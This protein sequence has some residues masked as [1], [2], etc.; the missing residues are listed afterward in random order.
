MGSAQDKTEG[1]KDRFKG[2][3]KEGIGKV[4]DDESLEAEGR[5]DQS[6][7]SAKE[8]K[9]KVKRARPARRRRASRTRLAGTEAGGPHPTNNGG[10]APCRHLPERDHVPAEP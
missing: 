6:K 4:T 5:K 10:L 2:K 9:G 8:A 1:K 3:V 7:G